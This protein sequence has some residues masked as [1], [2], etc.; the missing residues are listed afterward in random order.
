[1]AYDYIEILTSKGNGGQQFTVNK[2]VP[3]VQ[4]VTHGSFECDNAVAK[5]QFALGDNIMIIGAGFTLPESFCLSTNGF[6]AGVYALPKINLYLYTEPAHVKY[7][8]SIAGSDG[9]FFVPF[10]NFE[11][12]INSYVNVV[13]G[14]FKTN[15]AP[16]NDVATSIPQKFALYLSIE[17]ATCNISMVNVPTSLD[18][19][20][21]RITPFV[22]VAHN[23]PLIL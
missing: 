16:P 2:A 18:G 22:K 19:T 14:S 15:L 6:G 20:V 17:P 8:P 9:T 10:E 23:V 12:I 13:K 5:S 1:M 7:Y 11:Y 3:S 4:P 21:Q